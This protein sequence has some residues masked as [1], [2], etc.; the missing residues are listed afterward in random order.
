MPGFPRF[1]GRGHWDSFGFAE[2][3]GIRFVKGR[4]VFKGLGRGLRV[5]WH[6]PLPE[7]H[8]LLG[9]VLRRDA[10][11]WQVSLQF[12]F[13]QPPQTHSGPAVGLDRNP[14]LRGA[15]RW[16]DHL[17]SAH[18]SARRAK[19]APGSAGLGSLPT[20][21]AEAPASAGTAPSAHCQ[22]PRLLPA[23]AIR[24]TGSALFPDRRR[25]T[26]AP[27]PHRLGQGHA[28]GARTTG[29]DQSGAQPRAARRFRLQIF[30]LP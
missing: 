8:R 6:R 22:Y 7:G 20:T 16:S 13:P 10:K 11:G 4:L 9:A 14:S 1:K 30:P 3:S 29:Q 19:I 15:L 12:K 28:G 21:S 17:Q 5:H 23:S 18:G 2:W 25:E 24:R 26:P 27:A